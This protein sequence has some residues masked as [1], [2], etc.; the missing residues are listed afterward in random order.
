MGIGR[1]IVSGVLCKRG[2]RRA[3]DGGKVSEGGSDRER[4]RNEGGVLLFGE[5]AVLLGVDFV[6][7]DGRGGCRRKMWGVFF[8]RSWAPGA[9]VR[10]ISG[11]CLHVM[12]VGGASEASAKGGRWPTGTG[13]GGPSKR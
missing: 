7:R 12:S 3:V 11:G 2:R 8:W 6:A 4:G 10:R 1:L 5:Q 9:G 13:R